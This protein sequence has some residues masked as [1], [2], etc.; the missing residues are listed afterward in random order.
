MGAS[1]GP[2][3]SLRDRCPC[4]LPPPPSAGSLRSRSS[5]SLSTFG[6]DGVVDAELLSGKYK[7]LSPPVHHRGRWSTDC[8]RDECYRG[9]PGDTMD[10]YKLFIGGEFV[11]GASGERFETNS[12]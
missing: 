4:A 10:H 12:P 7:S 2:R 8:V 3:G 1:C 9:V 6:D 11:E 5:A